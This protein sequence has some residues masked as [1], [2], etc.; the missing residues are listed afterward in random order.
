MMQPGISVRVTN[1]ND[2]SIEDRYDGVP[3]VFLPGE[4]RD[5]DLATAA[6]IFGFPVDNEGRVT[7]IAADKSY[8]CRRWGWN[9][10]D[11]GIKRSPEGKQVYNAEQAM[12]N[13]D[14]AFDNLKV[15]AVEYVLTER[16]RSPDELPAPRPNPGREVEAKPR[17]RRGGRP[18]MTK[19]QK[20]AAR[21]ARLATL[22]P[23]QPA[24]EPGAAAA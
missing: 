19:E 22:T 6:H 10:P 15:E 20:A 9:R 16:K 23:E 7:A 18:K 24:V 4:S 1:G 17:K 5:V 12:R 11:F 14:T 3:E 13:A 2:F 21:A 8:V